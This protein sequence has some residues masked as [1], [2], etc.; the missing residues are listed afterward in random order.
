MKNILI[1]QMRPEDEA[2]DS[3][4]E[5]IVKVGKIN[6]DHVDRI[7]VEK[8]KKLDI[9]VDNYAA[10]IAGGSPFDVTCPADEKT[11][12]QRRIERFFNHLFEQII[13]KDFPF[14]GICSGNGLLGNYYGT[15]IS[16][17]YAEQIGHVML[18]INEEGAKDVLLRKLPINF[19]GFVG[20]KE[21]CDSLPYGAT[22]LVSS[23]TCPVQM[24]RIKKNIYATQF[25]PEAD[26]GEF[27]LRINT[28]K[29]YGYFPS[30]QADA[31]IKAVRG[32]ETPV[33]KEILRRFVETYKNR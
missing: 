31:L 2:C 28:Y 30:E 20:H 11:E 14:F 27:I 25:H 15:E 23:Q 18:T 21:A 7:R 22:L 33:P 32:I 9:N 29:N 6:R 16:G 19:T 13:A 24:F 17:K 8:L 1:L 26:E 5:A 10:I 4:F 12:E 3:E